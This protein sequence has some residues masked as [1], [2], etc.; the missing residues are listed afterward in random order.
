MQIDPQFQ[1]ARAS[2]KR[3]RARRRNERIVLWGGGAIGGIALLALLIWI[4]GLIFGGGD[5]LAAL[6]AEDGE[7]LIQLEEDE[8]AV[9]AITATPFVDIAGDPMILRFDGGG[10][11][12]RALPGPTTLDPTRVGAPNAERL[13]LVRD[14]L[15]VRE[16][17]L[18]TALPSSREDFAFFQAQRSASID[19]P[20]AFATPGGGESEIA[21]EK[22]DDATLGESSDSWG[23]SLGKDGAQSDRFTRTKIENT[24]SVTFLRAEAKREKIYED[25]I[26]LLEA[27]RKLESILAE[28]RFS[29]AQAKADTE[30]AVALLPALGALEKGAILAL[31][32]RPKTVNDDG[33]QIL[34]IALYGAD[35]GYL[36]SLARLGDGRFAQ[37]ADPWI[38]TNLRRLAAH[39]DDSIP[40]AGQKFRLLDAFY[41]AAIRNGVSTGVVGESIVMLSQA[42][43]L[44]IFASPG[45]KMQLL[46]APTPGPFGKGAGQ[47]LYAAI[48]GP[49]GEKECYVAQRPGMEGGFECYSA[50]IGARMGRLGG[51]MT[52]PVQGGTLS[53][54]FGPRHHPILKQVKLHAGVDWAAPT[55]TP[56]YAAFDGRVAHAG[57]GKG[58]GNLVIIDHSGGRQT[59][60][61]HLNKF[62]PLGKTGAQVRA[63]DLVGYVGTTGR[64]TGPHLHFEMRLGGRPVDPFGPE[65]I[66]AASGAPAAIIASGSGSGAAAALTDRII[67]VESGGNATA[68]NPLS[69]ATGLG[70]F[71]SSTW[72]R[73]MKTYRPDLYS[74][75]SKADLLALR[76]DPT[77]SREMVM[78]LARENE[79]YLRARG[80]QIS[81]GRLY[82]A[83][84]LGPEGANIVLGAPEEALILNVM[85]A[86]VVKA[87][88]FLA[89]YSVADLKRWADRK[90]GQKGPA[91]PTQ[92]AAPKPLPPEVLAYKKIID[93]ILEEEV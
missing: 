49:S 73:M 93:E 61:A 35:Q 25:V 86:S 4:G 84:F 2:S 69:S 38:D 66:A 9:E 30:R 19:A 45:D 48:K 47:V 51:G 27:P 3:R 72:L 42:F 14:E 32:L 36:G 22:I 11:A 37:A 85:G 59:R 76:N 70:Q 34:Q 16:K 80:H 15:M 8:G 65:A 12:K 13:I 77:L 81:A 67:R 58:Y 44:E 24:T 68:K 89:K 41:S 79:N 75:M 54:P 40:T 83:H 63:G 90:M 46:Y 29:D 5:R 18:I 31:R 6:E 71:I 55:G 87:N 1:Q 92:V 7:E 57:D 43:D 52:T 60:Y 53:S 78:N 10:S 17:R 28:N 88:P 21:S 56:V 62:A 26:I 64:S 82:L 50:G 39:T 20:I 23:E 74:T 33:P 91:L